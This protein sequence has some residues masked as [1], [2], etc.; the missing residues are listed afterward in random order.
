MTTLKDLSFLENIKLPSPPN[1]ALRLLEVI[2]KDEFSYTEIAL[3]IQYD[4]ALTAK[5]LKVANSSFYSFPNK[6]GN[7]ER[8]LELIGVPAVKNIVF[9]FNLVDRFQLNRPDVFN[10]DYFWKKSIISAIGTELFTKHFNINND[11]LFVA[12][13]LQDLGILILHSHHHEK[14]SRLIKEKNL[15]KTSIDVLEK[16]TFGFNHQELCAE[17]LEQ[18]G[19]PE[20]IYIPI[21]HHHHYEN[22]PEAYRLSARIL[23]LANALSSIYSDNEAFDK[24]DHFYNLIKNDLGI[25]PGDL[26]SL[27]DQGG[28][29]VIEICSLFQMSTKDIKPLATL[30]QEANE[31]LSALNLSYE[32]LLNEYKKEKMQAEK[33]ALELKEAV[34]RDYLTGLYNRRYLMDFL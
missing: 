24:I 31:G 26:E 15:T 21:R 4:P 25:P 20:S 13:L 18:W 14:Y 2:K 9:S 5:V 7:I 23:F 12:A 22:A 3:I 16:K 30:L 11:D 1:I 32:R 33:L 28:D 8:A 19:L 29:R 6:I 10:I 34:N 17:V 27:I